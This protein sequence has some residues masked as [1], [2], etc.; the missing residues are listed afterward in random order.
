[1]FLTIGIFLG[2]QAMESEGVMIRFQGVYDKMSQA[3]DGVPCEELGI[4]DE[5]KEQVCFFL[6]V[7]FYIFLILILL[8]LS[9]GNLYDFLSLFHYVYINLT[10]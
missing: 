5:V 7:P 8:K 1:M 2:F 4:S 10:F 9:A 3:F 6:Q